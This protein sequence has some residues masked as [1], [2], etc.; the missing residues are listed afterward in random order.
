MFELEKLAGEILDWNCLEGRYDAE[1]GRIYINHLDFTQY[2]ENK[3]G[4]PTISIWLPWGT[5]PPGQKYS[6]EQ[7]K[8]CLDRKALLIDELNL[9]SLSVR[10][11]KWGEA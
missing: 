8:K 1:K 4:V 2:I 9:M 7:T 6:K 3:G 10:F 5:V 11:K